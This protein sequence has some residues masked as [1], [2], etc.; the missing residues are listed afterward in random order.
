MFFSVRCRT[1]LDPGT[2]FGA[3]QNR[4]DSAAMTERFGRRSFPLI[5]M[6]LDFRYQ[7]GVPSLSRKRKVSLPRV[8]SRAKMVSKPSNCTFMPTTVTTSPLLK[9]K[10]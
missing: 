2:C 10:S 3:T 7:I 9:P 5:K 1:H 6:S 4:P 8:T